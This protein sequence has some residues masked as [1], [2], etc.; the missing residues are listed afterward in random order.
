MFYFLREDFDE[1]NSQIKAI[2][3]KIKAIAEDIGKSCQEG[4]ETYHDNFALEEGERQ[5]HMWSNRLRELIRVRNN[6]RVVM[7][8]T[9]TDRVSI[10]RMV[11][12]EDE[13]TGHTRTIK[14]GSYM[15]WKKD[16]TISYNAPLARLVINA[17]VGEVR[18]GTIA[19]EEVKLKIVTIE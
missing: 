4:S 13:S 2:C 9:T 6:S 10:G 1:L 3:E 7:P 15:T 17:R 12:L 11:V 19:G 5:Q 8:N 14:I 18:D 16:G